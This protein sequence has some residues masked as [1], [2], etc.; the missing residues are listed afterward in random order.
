MWLA[1]VVKRLFEKTSTNRQG[2]LI[3]LARGPLPPGVAT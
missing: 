2:D 1:C 3:R